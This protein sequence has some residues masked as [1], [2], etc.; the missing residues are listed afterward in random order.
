MTPT[1]AA[2]RSDQALLA[3]SI[4][5][6]G[7]HFAGFSLDG[8]A[9][10][11]ASAA[12]ILLFGLPH[13]SLDVQRFKDRTLTLTARGGLLGLYLATALGMGV[14][15]RLAPGEALLLFLGVSAVHFAEDWTALPSPARLACGWATLALPALFHHAAVREIF[16]QLAGRQAGAVGS[17]ILLMTA[18]VAGL[19]AAASFLGAAL[20]G[21]RRQGARGLLVLTIMA[22]L[23]PVAAFALYFCLSH[24]PR[25]FLQGFWAAGGGRKLWL[26]AVIPITV[27]A[28]GLAAAT[29]ALWSPAT[30]AA[31]RFAL[32]AL[33]PV[34]FLVLSALTLPHMSAPVLAQW[35]RSFRPALRPV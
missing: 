23:P 17:D 18:P 9:V 15:W 20:D 13:G 5:L 31:P 33:A 6:I 19:V 26:R 2:D 25:Q 14:L 34:S 7:C 21:H 3:G 32:G 35:V 27:L 12:A 30:G 1:E 28:Y 4:V 24:S 8:P 11:A 16:I 29:W 22:T 10:V